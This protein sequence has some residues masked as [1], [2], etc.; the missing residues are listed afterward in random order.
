MAKAEKELLNYGK[1]IE[2]MN[3]IGICFNRI[4]EEEAKI[5]ISEK[6]YYYK[7][8]SYRKLFHKSNNKYNIEFESLS[9]I[10]SIDMQLRYQL[11]KMCLDIEHSIKTKLMDAFVRNTQ[12]D[13]YNF[14]EKYERLYP[15][16]YN[17]C[18]NNLKY[19]PYLADMYKKRKDKLPI[20]VLIEIMS[21]GELL[22]LVE[23]YYL[24][25]TKK[26]RLQKAFEYG[27]FVR[28]IRNTCA[29]SNVFLLNIT[30]SR[31]KIS[32][33][34]VSV[35][36]QVHLK[37]DDINHPKLHDLFC[38]MILHHEYCSIDIQHHRRAEAIDLLKRAS[39]KGSYYKN[40]QDLVKTFKVIK[41]MLALLSKN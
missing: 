7:I 34:V 17:K 27:K 24:E 31:T 9:D 4:T 23:L 25:F 41:K 29:H 14:V 12:I 5:I 6:S 21:F 8:A 16:G 39:R 33:S 26:N 32:T 28:N 18:I 40:N 20:W 36:E 2:K 10:A 30:N 1:L 11:L 3:A 15:D 13:A 22:N 35:A 19:N 37:R 38:L